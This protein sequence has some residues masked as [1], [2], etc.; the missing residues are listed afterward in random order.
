MSESSEVNEVLEIYL[1]QQEEKISE[2]SRQLMML[3]TRYKLLEKRNA[4]MKESLLQYDVEQKKDSNRQQGFKHVNQQ[5]L[6][7][8]EAAAAGR[9]KEL[10]TGKLKIIGEDNKDGGSF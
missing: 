2:L 1:K 10:A 3:S 9:L 7:A 6:R 5:R 8:K 4:E